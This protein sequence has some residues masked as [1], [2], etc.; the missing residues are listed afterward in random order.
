M[1]IEIEIDRIVLDGFDL[2][3]RERPLL[4]MAVREELTR[5][6]A[7]HGL[8]YQADIAHRRIVG[9]DITSS[10]EQTPNQ[11]GTSIAQAVYGG[12]SR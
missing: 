9:S 8:G 10:Q 6:L 5:L 2:S 4:E 11:F 3:W 1:N 12:L 7:E